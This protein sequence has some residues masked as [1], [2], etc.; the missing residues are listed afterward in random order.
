MKN[1]ATRARSGSTVT[2]VPSTRGRSRRVS[3]AN[4]AAIITAVRLVVA[5]SP[6]SAHPAQSISVGAELVSLGG[7]AG[8][9]PLEGLVETGDA[10]VLQGQADVVHVDADG[11]Q[12]AHHLGCLLH[13]GVEGAG[14][15]AVVLEGGDGGL[16]QRVDGVWP[17]ELVDVQGV[18][19]GG[20]L[21]GRRGPQRP[22]SVRAETGQALPPLAGEQ[23]LE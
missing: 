16:G 2:S 19:V 11:G 23:L 18:G 7:E 10:L 6:N 21:G 1:P 3:P 8:Q 15:A 4:W 5:I 22:L 13:A 20:V 14:Q 17:D 12:S 9:H